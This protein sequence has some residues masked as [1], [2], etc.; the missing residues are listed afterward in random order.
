M[1]N[2]SSPDVHQNIYY[3][4]ST[5]PSSSSPSALLKRFPF[6]PY[7][8]LII[9]CVCGLLWFSYTYNDNHPFRYSSFE[10]PPK[11]PYLWHGGSPS[12]KGSCWCSGIDSYCL[13]TPSLAIDA[14]IL[15]KQLEPIPKDSK[16]P[17]NNC[18]DASIV[19]VVRKDP[20]KELHAIPGGFVEVGETTENAVMRE[21]KEETNLTVSALE[22]FRLYSEPHRDP[23]RHTVSMVYII[24]QV[25]SLTY[26][27][28]GDDAKGVRLVPLK[29]IPSLH[30]AFDHRKILYDFLTKYCPQIIEHA[31]H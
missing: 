9:T 15:S 16:S 30:L 28:Q 3:P 20:P 29:E 25:D 11:C 27:K 13:C 6:L 24:H 1:H 12:H 14:L 10:K 22:Q 17:D 26:L 21:V 23:R 8:F 18:M 31:A 4:Q 19:L 5:A 2:T 7:V